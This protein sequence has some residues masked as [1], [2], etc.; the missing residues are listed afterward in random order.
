M[1]AA[2]NTGK[3]PIRVAAGL[4]GTL[5]RGDVSDEAKNNAQE[6]LKDM[7]CEEYIAHPES[8]SDVREK[9]EEEKHE[10]HVQGGYKATLKNPNVSEEAKENARQHLGSSEDKEV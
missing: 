8:S 10:N 9:S 4:K 1:S 5:A 7:G 6:R 2:D 3:D